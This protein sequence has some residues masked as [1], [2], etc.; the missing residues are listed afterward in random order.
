MTESDVVE[1]ILHIEGDRLLKDVIRAS[2]VECNKLKSI[3]GST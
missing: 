3:H 2:N 1:L